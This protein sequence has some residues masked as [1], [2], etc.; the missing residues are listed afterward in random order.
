MVVTDAFAKFA[1]RMASTQGWPYV[2]I[3][4]TENPIRQ[5]E[6]EALAR[7]VA[8]QRWYAA[9]GEPPRRVVLVDH[10]EWGE[11]GN[12][13]VSLYRVE[14]DS[15]ETQN[16]FLPLALAWEDGAEERLQGM[17]AAT[18]AR[19]RQQAQLGVL[20]DA[21]ADEAFCR[22]LVAAIGLG[23]ELRCAHGVIRFAPTQAYAEIAGEASSQLP[24]RPVGSPGSNT[25]VV[26][27][28]RLFLKGY[29]RLH[30][31][32]NPEAEIGRFLTEKVRF[33][34]SV[35]VAG[36]VEYGGGDGVT[37]SLALLQ[38][39]VENQGDGWSYALDYLERFL[40]QQ[41][42]Q[43]AAPGNAAE[44]HGAWLTLVRTLGQRTGEL[45]RALATTTGD[46]AFDPE[47][48]DARDLPAWVQRARDEA[49]AAMDLLARRRD[50]LADAPRAAADRLLERRQ[51]LFARIDGC[52]GDKLSGIKI[53]HH[54][55]YHLGQVLLRQNDFVIIDFEGEPARPLAE[56]RAKHS[57]LRDVAGML[58]SF[59]Y[60][61]HAALVRV[62][63][64]RADGLD[65]LE[66]HA[67]QW[68]LETQR[69][70][71]EAYRDATHG[72]KLYPSWDEVRGL[73]ELFQLEKAFYE[74]RYELDNRPAWV[75]IVL[76]GIGKLARFTA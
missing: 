14:N 61:A 28:D 12:W 68:E 58:R 62:T 3:A 66:R 45:H 22:A 57:P 41:R 73:L 55:D 6:T 49:G 16:Y 25:G 4:E 70:F 39:Y 7:F 75:L 34:H 65:L 38:S 11:Q 27:G 51:E 8:T 60:A 17:Q 15:S 47:P 50:G 19:V 1:R 9:K 76:Q 10:A 21:F 20:A 35:P 18:V 13:L 26:L 74:L 29:R 37:L 31:G 48:I 69:R 40:E 52:A 67:Q 72:C 59:N 46:P 33:P 63:A 23:Q 24:V 54:G 44:L 71:V 42:A 2:I 32:V 36:T 56:R 43:G 53:R 30:P 5:L 64:E